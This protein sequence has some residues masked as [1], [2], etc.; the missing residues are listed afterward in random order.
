MLQEWRYIPTSLLS[1][2]V[3]HGYSA[4]DP[5]PFHDDLTFYNIFF[6][7]YQL[8]DTAKALGI[9]FGGNSRHY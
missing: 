4:I 2:V 8:N 5:L 1:T 3:V 9:C 6:L 7:Y